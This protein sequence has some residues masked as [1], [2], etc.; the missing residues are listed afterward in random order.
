MNLQIDYPLDTP[1]NDQVLL[2]LFNLSNY[3][4]PLTLNE[5]DD[6]YYNC[7]I[8]P[9]Y[10]DETNELYVD[11]ICNNINDEY[12]N[13][14]F[15]DT[16][17]CFNMSN[18]L[19]KEKLVILGNK[20]LIP[21]IKSETEGLLTK[22]YDV[23]YINNAQIAYKLLYKNIRNEENK[24]IL[25]VCREGVENE[26]TLLSMIDANNNPNKYSSQMHTLTNLK[27]VL[28]STLNKSAEET[29]EALKQTRLY[30]DVKLKKLDKD[31]VMYVFN[32]ISRSKRQVAKNILKSLGAQFITRN[33]I[34]HT[35]KI[36]KKQKMITNNNYSSVL[37]QLILQ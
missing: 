21:Q 35:K 26:K 33:K 28:I 34:N 10:F 11:E 8:C 14:Y 37:K 4:T 17:S 18:G 16:T 12:D 19:K 29:W 15:L 36:G 23:E 1:L 20:V 5:D 7:P 32:G 27:N 6:N 31:G 30:Q 9:N 22:K 13:G 24:K 3:S 25:I 2:S